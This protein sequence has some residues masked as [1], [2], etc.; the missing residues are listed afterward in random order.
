MISESGNIYYPRS[1]EYLKLSDNIDYSSLRDY[2]VN[3]AKEILSNKCG[4]VQTYTGY[5]KTYIMS[6]LCNYLPKPILITEPTLVLCEEIRSRI[7]DMTDIYIINPTAYFARKDRDDS[8][9][10]DIKTLL[11]DEMMSVTESIKKV[12]QNILNVDRV[13]GFSATPDKMN[14]TR[15]QFLYDGLSDSTCEIIQYYGL[16]IVYSTLRKCIRV[17]E[18]NVKLGSCKFT[19]DDYEHWK[20]RIAINK[21]FK[22]PNLVNYLESCILR[23]NSPILFPFT[24]HKQIEWLMN[25]TTLSK[26]RLV[27]W[28]AYSVTLNNG[29]VFTKDDPWKNSKGIEYTPYELI[30]YMINNNQ[31]NVVFCSSVGFKGVDITGLSNIILMIGSNAGNVIQMVGRVCRSDNPSIFLPK[32]LDDNQLYEVSYNKRLKWIKSLQI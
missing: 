24:D 32:N 17:Y 18:D 14:N 16:T 19:M 13:Y 1:N 3:D 23:C 7:N 9:M 28:D 12:F 10:M 4:L 22:S 27:L 11:S 29:R 2:Q 8:W 5:G 6:W 31:V 15:L 21:C 25:D 20:Y 30:K 26:Y